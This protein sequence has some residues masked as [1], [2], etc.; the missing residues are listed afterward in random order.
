MEYEEYFGG[1][2]VT[3]TD[4]EVERITRDWLPGEVCKYHEEKGGVVCPEKR[5]KPGDCDHC[6]WNPKV[7]H[8]RSY[9]IRKMLYEEDTGNN[10]PD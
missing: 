4:S 8:R 6:G 5:R 3:L 7:A 1:A 2:L 9:R 10:V